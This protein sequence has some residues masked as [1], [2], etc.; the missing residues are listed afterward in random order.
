MSAGGA[1]P[2]GLAELVLPALAV[3]AAAAERVALIR[4]LDH[5]ANQSKARRVFE[6][7]GDRGRQLW[8]VWKSRKTADAPA[9]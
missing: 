9:S 1:A 5:Y 2:F 6:Q 7:V 3:Q 4:R 8:N